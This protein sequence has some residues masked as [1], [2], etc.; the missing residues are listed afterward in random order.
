MSPAHA[1]RIEQ[2]RKR[3]TRSWSDL[4]LLACLERLESGGPTEGRPVHVHDASPLDDTDGIWVVY[5]YPGGRPIGVRVLRTSSSEHPLYLDAAGA[6]DMDDPG[7]FGHEV[8][9]HVIGEPLGTIAGQLVDDSAGVGWW[10]EPPF[11]GITE[12][13]TRLPPVAERSSL[14][15]L[16]RWL[17]RL[18]WS[19]AQRSDGESLVPTAPPG[20]MTRQ[21]PF[22]CV[23][24]CGRLTRPMVARATPIIATMNPTAIT[25]ASRRSIAHP[26][27]VSSYGHERQG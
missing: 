12:P 13:P 1:R 10:G 15:R 7:E 21:R 9:D 26:T 27:A 2:L 18:S 24:L 5:S 20:G 19:S 17:A 25:V 8:A 22:H 3:S 16:R 23:D 4:A 6:G 14:S 11:P